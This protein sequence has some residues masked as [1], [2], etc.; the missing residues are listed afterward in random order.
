MAKKSDAQ[1]SDAQKIYQGL[2]LDEVMI[3]EVRKGFDVNL[4][5]QKIKNDTTF[6]KAFKSLRLLTFNM[7]NDIQIFDKKENTK[8]SLNSVTKQIRKNN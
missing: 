4:F 2:V 8:A 6:Y 1:T 5:I 7:Y 3:K